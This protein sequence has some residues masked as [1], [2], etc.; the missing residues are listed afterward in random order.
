M[1]GERLAKHGFGFCRTFF[2]TED[3]AQIVLVHRHAFVPVGLEINR[4]GLAH[5][6][7]RLLQFAL[8]PYRDRQVAKACCNSGIIGTEYLRAQAKRV[9]LQRFCFRKFV[10]ECQLLSQVRFA[11]RQIGVMAARR[12]ASKR[13]S[14]LSISTAA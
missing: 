9:A 13:A 3:N 8:A 10:L 2:K 12:R 14:S 6:R 11:G 4:K 1:D 5:Q 7:F